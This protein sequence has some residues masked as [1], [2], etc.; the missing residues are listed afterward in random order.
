MTAEAHPTHIALGIGATMP[1]IGLGVYLINNAD[2]CRRSVAAALRSGY[3]LIDTAVIY[4]NERAVGD[5]LAASD[6][7]RADV[8]ITTKIWL[9]DY[10]YERA[11]ASI[12]A[13][14][15]RLG[16]DHV[17]LMLLHQPGPQALEAWRAMEEAVDEGR[18]K[19]IGV[20]NF[21]PED[22]E[23][24]LD[25]ARIRPTVNQIEM[26]PYYQRPDLVAHLRRHGIVVES[27]APLGHRNKKLLAEPLL[28]DL[29]AKHDCS[30]HQVLLRWHLQSGFVAIPKS[31]NPAHIASNIDVYGF[32][33]TDGDMAAIAG[34][35]KGR[36]N[37]RIPKWVL[38]HL[39]P[40]VRPR[41][42]A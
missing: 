40:R 39:L 10:P 2:E 30:V 25:G 37:F 33:L 21:E 3:R 6:V 13:S 38:K 28:A 17:D 35:D 12:D 1:T 31:T 18:I 8:F 23:P 7:P 29:A 4:G 22:L 36:P 14:L 24:I 5:A 16:T 19:A 34:L 20:S 15:E 9:H 11:R 26:H 32:E 42:F 41:Q 27:W